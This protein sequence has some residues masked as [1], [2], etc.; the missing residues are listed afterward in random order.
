MIFMGRMIYN[1]SYN[2]LAIQCKQ[3]DELMI[4]NMISVLKEPHIIDLMSNEEVQLLLEVI[5][6][7]VV[8]KSEM[9][10]EV[11]QKYINNNGRSK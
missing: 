6:N 5:K 3:I 9:T 2:E 10:L 4:A 11:Q 1:E 7:H 8:L